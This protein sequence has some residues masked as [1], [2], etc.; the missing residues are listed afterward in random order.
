MRR[1]RR[2]RGAI[3]GIGAPV[4]GRPRRQKQRMFAGMDHMSRAVACKGSK[5]DAR[6]GEGKSSAPAAK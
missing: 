5:G 1:Y 6:N 2:G 3:G 4:D